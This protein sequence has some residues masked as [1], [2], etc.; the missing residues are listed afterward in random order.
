MAI[1]DRPWTPKRKP[2]MEFEE[3]VRYVFDRP[4]DFD[5]Y[6][7]DGDLNW[8]QKADVPIICR[9]V[10]DLFSRSGELLAPYSDDQIGSALDH[11][12]CVSGNH[13]AIRFSKHVQLADR[14]AMIRAIESLYRRVFAVRCSNGLAHLDQIQR[15]RLDGAVYMLWDYQMILSLEG[16]DVDAVNLA[17][18]DVLERVLTIDNA[19]VQE[20]AIHGLGHARHDYSDRADAILKNWIATGLAAR[21]ELIAYAERARTDG[22]E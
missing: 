14:V 2:V 17:T 22:V 8:E 13:M 4:S 21:P 12:F 3:W 1:R 5:R 20:S 11:L 10:T 15:R 18:I 6:S 9:Y 16:S 19:I 7:D